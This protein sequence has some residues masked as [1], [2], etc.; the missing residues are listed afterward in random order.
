MN[1]ELRFELSGNGFSGMPLARVAKYMT[2]LAD[3]VGETAMFVRMTD[4]QIVFI[5]GGAQSP[6][7]TTE[8]A[9]VD[10]SDGGAQ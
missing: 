1:A 8:S 6:V 2:A 4:N 3:L 5:E 9:E 10:S 7:A